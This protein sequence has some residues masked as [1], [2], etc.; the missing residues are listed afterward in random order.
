MI[1]EISELI[2]NGYRLTVEQET[3]YI[4]IVKKEVS[5]KG[6]IFL[7]EKIKENVYIPDSYI[8]QEIFIYRNPKEMN[9]INS[10]MKSNTYPEIKTHT[11]NL[12]KKHQDLGVNIWFNQFN[13]Y[14]KELNKNIKEVENILSTMKKSTKLNRYSKV[15]FNLCKVCDVGGNR[16]KKILA[17][18]ESLEIFIP[19]LNREKLINSIVLLNPQVKSYKKL[20]NTVNNYLHTLKAHTHNTHFQKEIDFLI[21]IN[22][23][24][25]SKED[26]KDRKEQLKNQIEVFKENN[27]SLIDDLMF[28]MKNLIENKF[29]KESEEYLNNLKQCLNNPVKDFIVNQLTEKTTRQVNLQE[30]ELSLP[31]EIKELLNTIKDDGAYCLDNIEFLNNEQKYRLD[32]IITKQTQKIVTQYLAVNKEYRKN[33]DI[34]NTE[35]KTAYDLARESLLEIVKLLNE[36]KEDINSLKVRDLSVTSRQTKTLSKG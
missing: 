20:L 27:N 35:N 1:K 28:K 12:L 9:F 4:E 29:S 31:I 33:K 3:S 5:V 17:L 16:S 6:F 7:E 13:L 15:L 2:S 24:F 11:L 22:R 25:A 8:E 32:F 36:Y 19:Y 34:V 26:F 14:S 23:E 21:N 10:V 18:N 30:K